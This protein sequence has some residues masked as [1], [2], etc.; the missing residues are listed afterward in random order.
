[1]HSHLLYPRLFLI[2]MNSPLN[3]T[4]YERSVQPEPQ[5]N[6]HVTIHVSLPL[7]FR[8]LYNIQHT[9]DGRCPTDTTERRQQSGGTQYGAEKHPVPCSWGH[10]LPSVPC[11][12]P[13]LR[14][15]TQGGLGS[16]NTSCILILVEKRSVTGCSTRWQICFG[17]CTSESAN[18]PGMKEI[19]N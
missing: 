15:G 13:V 16:M 9:E 12:P 1:M 4:G 11:C 7:S 10:R 3:T 17:S 8:D 19:E 5:K 18:K 2:R 14:Y 6:R